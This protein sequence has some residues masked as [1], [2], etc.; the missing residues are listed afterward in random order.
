METCPMCEGKGKRAMENYPITGVFIIFENKITFQRA[1][2]I[3]DG[4]YVEC[5]DNYNILWE[6][7]PGGGEP[8]KIGGYFDLINAIKAGAELM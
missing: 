8:I 2:Y 5:V 1:N 4:W 3:E 7:P 6:I